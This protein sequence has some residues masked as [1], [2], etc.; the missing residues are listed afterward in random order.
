[1]SE[2]ENVITD[3]IKAIEGTKS[4]AELSFEDLSIKLPGMKVGVVIT[5]SVSF[6]ARPIH[7][8]EKSD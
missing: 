4:S 5:G 7:G 3:I 6:T 2:E 8:R 1:M